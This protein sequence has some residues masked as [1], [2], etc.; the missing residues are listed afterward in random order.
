MLYYEY[1]LAL[2][3][4]GAVDPVQSVKATAFAPVYNATAIH[5][6]TS[7]KGEHCFTAESHKSVL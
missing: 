3:T 1:S 5:I 6:H 7:A 2:C 4:E